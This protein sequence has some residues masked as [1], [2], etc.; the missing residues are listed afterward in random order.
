MMR[1][2]R[3]NGWGPRVGCLLPGRW[4][5]NIVSTSATLCDMITTEA[6]KAISLDGF[7]LSVGAPASL[8][9]LDAPDKVEALRRHAPPAHVV[10]NGKPVDAAKMHAIVAAAA[11]AA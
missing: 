2:Q 3:A 7:G 10:S 11:G 6:A 5:L 9:V 1:N 8:V 4:L